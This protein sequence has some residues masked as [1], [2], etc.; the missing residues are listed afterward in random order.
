MANV[1]ADR[2]Y[3]LMKHP[4]G[5][6]VYMYLDDPG[7]Y[8]NAFATEVPEEFAAQAGFPV[9]KYAKLKLRRVKM[10]QAQALIDAELMADE[11]VRK[12]LKVINGFQLIKLPMDRYQILDPDG[13]ALTQ[14]IAGKEA[15]ERIYIAVA[16][17]NDKKAIE[18]YRKENVAEPDAVQP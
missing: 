17:D 4:S 12:V 7:V 16:F 9:E 5:V 11:D 13:V 10:A 1:D 8:L 3:M 6:E 14:P 15:V 2:G 18:K